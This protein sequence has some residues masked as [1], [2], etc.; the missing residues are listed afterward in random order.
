MAMSGSLKVAE[1][2]GAVVVG[3][4]LSD[5]GRRLIVH[6]CRLSHDEEGT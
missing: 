3:E 4:E 6:E 2:L 5:A 1:R